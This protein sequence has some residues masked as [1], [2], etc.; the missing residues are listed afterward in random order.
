VWTEVPIE[1]GT[2]LGW[3]PDG[4]YVVTDVRPS[5]AGGIDIDLVAVIDA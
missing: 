4:P 1:P 2:R 3:G 5:P